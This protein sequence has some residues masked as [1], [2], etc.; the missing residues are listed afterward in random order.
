MLMMSREDVASLNRVVAVLE[1]E[2][3]DRAGTPVGLLF[4]NCSGDFASLH[5]GQSSAETEPS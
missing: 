2:A 3:K 4:A 1:A 5:D